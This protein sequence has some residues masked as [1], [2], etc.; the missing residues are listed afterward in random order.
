MANDKNGKKLTTEQCKSQFIKLYPEYGTVGA[1]LKAIGIR[2]RR[3]LYLWLK[4]DANFA[5]VYNEELLPNRRDE[6]ASIVYRAARGSLSLQKD[7]LTA[8]FGFLKA[9]DHINDDLQFREKYQHEV[10]G[11]DGKP[12]QIEVDAKSKLLSLLNSIASRSREAEDYKYPVPEG[13]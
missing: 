2:S 11:Q 4:G 10:S 6:I 3:T 5:R 7:Q 1:T 12:I 13:S 9:T 8:A